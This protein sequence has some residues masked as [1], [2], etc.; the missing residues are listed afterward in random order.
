MY[1]YKVPVEGSDPEL[2]LF[3]NYTHTT[4]W[5]YQWAFSRYFHIPHQPHQYFL[6]HSFKWK[7]TIEVSCIS[8]WKNSTYSSNSDTVRLCEMFHE[9][10]QHS[11]WLWET[12]CIFK[13][14]INA[15]FY[16]IYTLCVTWLE[17]SHTGRLWLPLSASKQAKRPG[18]RI[19][20][21]LQTM[22][23]PQTHG[24]VENIFEGTCQQL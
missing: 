7:S 1:G 14:R 15:Y 18:F 4:N 16:G 17:P 19:I 13:D 5:E 11:S 23:S 12:S 9:G 24:A 20:S 8:S 21:W 22:D 3:F 10:Y 2:F 6:N